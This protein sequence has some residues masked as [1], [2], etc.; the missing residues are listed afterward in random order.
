MGATDAGFTLPIGRVRAI[1]DLAGRRGW[2][3]E[4]MLEE[5]GIS[6][7]LLEQGRARVT[8]DQAVRMVQ[9][10]WR[11]TD[12]ELFGLGL[13]PMPRGT[14]RLVCFGLLGAAT[15][16]AAIRRFIGFQKSLP[17]FPPLRL[18]VSADEARVSFDI[19]GIRH[20]VGLIIDTM[21]MIAHRFLGWAVGGRIRLRRVEVP[22]PPS[23]L[24]DYGLIFGA[25][26]VFSAPEP[27]L[28]FDAA[29]LDMPL[30]RTEEDLI[31]FLRDA[32]S[33]LI[34]RRDYAVSP[35][36]QV[37][38]ILERGLHGGWPGVD[39]IAAE[40]SMSPQTLRRKLREERT[41]LREIREQILR[42]AAIASLVRGEETVTALSRRLGFSEPSAFS[43]AFRRWTGSPPGSYRQPCSSDPVKE[44][45]GAVIGPTGRRS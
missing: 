44:T 16:G 27:A 33:G 9:R 35:A 4:G 20:P 45:S 41:S 14:F 23:G 28:V 31:D 1:V 6:P 38:H 19:S 3:G 43:R 11:T 21:L 5:A 30:V 15:V 42:D 18:T 39:D 10:L 34:G 17:G 37:R 2:D 24:D 7:A 32:P 8:V 26:V 13:R 22:Y 40:L 25:P 12:D 36:A 29:T